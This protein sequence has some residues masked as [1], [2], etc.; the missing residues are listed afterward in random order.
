MIGS[1]ASTSSISPEGL[2]ITKPSFESK[3]EVRDERAAREEEVRI[4]REH[5]Y[6]CWFWERGAIDQKLDDPKNTLELL[7]YC[8]RMDKRCLLLNAREYRAE[9]LMNKGICPTYELTCRCGTPLVRF[10]RC[11]PRKG[12]MESFGVNRVRLLKQHQKDE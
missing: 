6:N 4:W 8:P 3:Q 11:L 7:H 9:F 1:T 12:Y 10:G 5:Y 2:T